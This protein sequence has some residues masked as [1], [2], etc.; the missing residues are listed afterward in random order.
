VRGPALG[1][2]WWWLVSFGTPAQNERFLEVLA[3]L[4]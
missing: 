4:L 2:E 3:R 1:R